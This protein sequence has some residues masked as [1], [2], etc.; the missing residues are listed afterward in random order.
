MLR[1]LTAKRE[2]NHN[3]LLR[4]PTSALFDCTTVTLNIMGK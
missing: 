2:Q 1:L 4:D 3:W